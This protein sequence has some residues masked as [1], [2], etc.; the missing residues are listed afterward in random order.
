[1]PRSRLSH[2]LT[3]ATTRELTLVCAPAGSGKTT[4][5]ADWARTARQP[6]AWLSMDEGD[7]D[8]VRFWRYVAAALDQLHGGIERQLAARLAGPRS[9]HP[10][11]VMATL[12][13]TLTA[14]PDAA[15]LVVDDY[16]MIDAPAVHGSLTRLLELL[17]P[18]LRVVLASR[19]EPPLPLG[20]W[21]ARGQ[22]AELRTAD[23]AF[24]ADEAAALLSGIAGAALDDDA[25]D[26]LTRRTEDGS[27]VSSWPACRAT[28]PTRTGSS[29]PSPAATGTCSTT[30]PRRS[31]PGSPTRWSASCWRPRC[32]TRCAGRWPRWSPAA[33]TASSCW[34]R[35]NAPTCSSS[36]STTSGAG[37]AFT[38]CSPTCCRPGS[39][40]NS[41]AVSPSCIARR[42]RGGKGTTP[43]PASRSGRRPAAIRHALAAGDPGWAAR[44]V[45]R[46][47][48]AAFHRAEETT[49]ARWLAA[50]PDATV[51][52]RPR[53]LVIRAFLALLG[54]RL[55][56][57]EQ[58]I[59]DAESTL[60]TAGDESFEP[61]VGRAKSM[62]ANLPAAV[63]V[64]RAQLARFRGDT[65]GAIANRRRARAALTSADRALGAVVDWQLA[66]ADWLQGRA[67]RRASCRSW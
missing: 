57:T 42:P 33:A 19:A 46:H 43:R 10:D 31:W 66:V 18:Q 23:L 39:C 61:S 44:L 3:E 49:L 32:W 65:D 52:S 47:F 60:E 38:G 30:W 4:L 35:S 21:R 1:M 41:P 67:G 51:G 50:M 40:T 9:F 29:R 37:G 8:V 14:L 16:H 25:V 27:P 45:E 24:R 55:D 22:L 13:N 48:D 7:N 12:V 63:A 62:V 58:L 64:L 11:M 17:P 15:L 5:L 54:G 6:V 34:S 20:R 53:L 59:A 36:H 26:A 56:E 28:T 2:R